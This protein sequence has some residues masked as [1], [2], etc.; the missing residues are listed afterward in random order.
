MEI[1]LAI[2]AIASAIAS[3]V[4]AL[5]AYHAIQLAHRPT[6]WAVASPRK[7]DT[8]RFIGVQIHNGG[9]GVALEVAAARSE[10]TQR[11]VGTFRKVEEWKESDPTPFVRTLAPGERTPASDTDWHSV[12]PN[13]SG[14]DILG[15]LVR[16]SDT[17]GKR[18]QIAVEFDQRRL[19]GTPRRVRTRARWHLNEQQDTW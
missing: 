7:E 3:A 12:G 9:P 16:Y 6:V 8:E 1:A 14:D 13:R 17:R 4:S 19:A 2:A 18:W 15:V 11:R 10:P 5:V